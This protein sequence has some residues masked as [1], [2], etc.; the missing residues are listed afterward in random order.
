MSASG[1]AFTDVE[2]RDNVKKTIAV[3]PV[4]EDC[5]TVAQAHDKRGEKEKLH[6]L[7]EKVKKGYV[8]NYQ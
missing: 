6:N 5:Y 8:Q 1:H 2:M 7:F 3:M 4:C